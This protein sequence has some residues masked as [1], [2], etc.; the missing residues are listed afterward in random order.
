VWRA[1][2]SA[3]DR[4]RLLGALNLL[5]S[6]LIGERDAAALA[7]G[8]IISGAGLSWTEII[9]EAEPQL[10][11]EAGGDAHC[12]DVWR[13]MAAALL[14]RHGEVFNAAETDFLR[15]AA[16]LLRL[17]EKQAAWLTR[18]AERVRRGARAA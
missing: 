9:A 16:G 6:P 7:A 15:N 1:V 17:S 12:E 8:R 5:S 13:G 2:L 11:N 3:V 10:R 18:L 14:Q 4:R